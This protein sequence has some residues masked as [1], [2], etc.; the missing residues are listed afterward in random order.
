ME[1]DTVSVIVPVYNVEKYLDT[2]IN[3]LLNQSYNKLEIIL[4]D[5][6]SSDDSGKLCDAFEQENS[7]IKVIHKENEGL[8]L[9]RNAGLK[10]AQGK[11][12]TF[13]DSDDLLGTSAIEDL[14]KAA[15]KNNAD[16][17]IGG[18]TRINRNGEEIFEEQYTR[19]IALGKEKSQDVFIQMLGSLPE[20]HKSLKMSVWNC[21]YRLDLIKHYNLKFVSERELISE[22]IIWHSEYFKYVNT[23]VIIDNTAY[24]YRENQKS[25]TQS[26]NSKRFR[27]SMNLYFEL[28]KRINENNLNKEAELRNKK[29]LFINIR[30]CIAQEKSQNLKQA[31]KN[32]N[33]I[34]KDKDLIQI[35]ND[36]PIS[37]L[38]L[39]QRTFLLMLKHRW[40]L[41]LALL[42][43]GL[44]I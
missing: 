25:L 36:Y 1:N 38:E 39:K 5:D 2:C 26:Y 9:S 16:I 24:Y 23:S 22:D 35:I 44:V 27:L 13:V 37:R 42:S 41:A 20:S 15:D 18:F 34:T 28:T 7:R 31:V 12:V 29:Q 40:N 32:I 43:K 21:L 33:T 11:Y 6:G 14:V 3:S 19:R 8:G 4:I 17:C 10:I 30:T